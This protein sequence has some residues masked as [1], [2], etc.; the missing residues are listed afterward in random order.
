MRDTIVDDHTHVRLD[1]S[2]RRL[3]RPVAYASY[4]LILTTRA[5]TRATMLRFT[6][7]VHVL[8]LLTV[9]L[10]S[11]GEGDLESSADSHGAFIGGM[12][13]PDGAVD[14][15]YRH[16]EASR[17]KRN[18]N[19][20]V[21]RSWEDPE[22][23]VNEDNDLVEYIVLPP[24]RLNKRRVRSVSTDV[25]ATQ[26]EDP[27]ITTFEPTANTTA[28]NEASTTGDSDPTS[29]TSTGNVGDT[30]TAEGSGAAEDQVPVTRCRTYVIFDT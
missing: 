15:I 2:S 20:P 29:Q 27:M 10:A 24:K 4:Y 13:S 21:E 9:C 26:S 22:Q 19:L 23:I 18:L 5:L 12:M 30:T 17:T 25:S 11:S 3:R 7:L 28:I 6:Q 14:M 16:D 8:T 1:E